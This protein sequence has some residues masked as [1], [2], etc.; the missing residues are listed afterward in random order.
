MHQLMRLI[1]VAFKDNNFSCEHVT[2]F[3]KIKK[4]G[5]GNISGDWTR[6]KVLLD[7]IIKL[8]TN[9]NGL[10][11]YKIINTLISFENIKKL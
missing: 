9:F 7:Y 5:G 10:F 4:R 1:L 8:Y 3:M 2:N 6:N 11:M